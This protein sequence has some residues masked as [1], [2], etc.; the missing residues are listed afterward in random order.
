MFEGENPEGIPYEKIANALN[1]GTKDLK[2]NP[3]Y[4]YTKAIRK[5]KSIDKDIDKIYEEK[6]KELDDRS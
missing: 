3:T 5:L 6:M 4:F 2:I 1:Y